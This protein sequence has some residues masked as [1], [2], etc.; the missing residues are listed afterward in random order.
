MDINTAYSEKNREYMRSLFE[1][2]TFDGRN[3]KNGVGIAHAGD[4]EVRPFAACEF[5]KPAHLV[6]LRPERRTERNT[7]RPKARTSKIDRHPSVLI[8]ADRNHALQGLK[9]NAACSKVL[10]HAD[11]PGD[12]SGAI[13]ALLDLLAVA[14]KD[15]VA[16]I[17]IVRT[18]L[19]ENQ[20]LVGSYAPAAVGNACKQSVSKSE[21]GL[22]EV[23][24]DE[25]VACPFHLDKGNHLHR[26]IYAQ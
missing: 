5:D 20:H 15:T 4:V 1:R 22:R 14:V 24:H 10:L 2:K 23:K 16:E 13:A 8:L 3:E 7:W 21:R 18:S 9:S 19:L 26:R 11:E 17:R 6:G 25:I 12:A